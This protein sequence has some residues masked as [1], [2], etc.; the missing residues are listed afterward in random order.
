MF[1]LGGI[2]D[3]VAFLNLFKVLI[4]LGD[5]IYINCSACKIK[6]EGVCSRVH[7]VKAHEGSKGLEFFFLLLLKSNIHN[8]VQHCVPVHVNC[9]LNKR[10]SVS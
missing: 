3:N 10:L 5:G 8:V 7:N 1:I 9:I 4:F 2:N 6:G